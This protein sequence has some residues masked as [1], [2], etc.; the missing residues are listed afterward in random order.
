M[1]SRIG[2]GIDGVAGAHASKTESLSGSTWSM[3]VTGDGVALWVNHIGWYRLRVRIANIRCIVWCWIYGCQTT[4]HD[5]VGVL[6]TGID[7]SMRVTKVNIIILSRTDS[8]GKV[9]V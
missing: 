4:F 7:R 3:S 8:T 6:R 9:I 2:R 1:D 5:I